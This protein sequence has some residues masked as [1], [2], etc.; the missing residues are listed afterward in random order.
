MD[1]IIKVTPQEL[2]NAA[3]EFQSAGQQ[4][5]SATD[6]MIMMVSATKSTWSGEAATAYNNK[7]N[8]LNDDMV[9]IYSMINEHVKDLTEMARTYQEAENANVEVAS[10]L[11]GD[12]I[13]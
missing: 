13:E 3:N 10:G 6:K 5:K 2:T 11:T 9:K 1:G 8:Q 7:F 4:V 12:I